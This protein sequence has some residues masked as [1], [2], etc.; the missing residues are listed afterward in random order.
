LS[1]TALSIPVNGGA[2]LA[3]A[4]ATPVAAEPVATDFIAMVQQMLLGQTPAAPEGAMAAVYETLDSATGKDDLEEG[5]TNEC[6]GLAALLALLP[7]TGADAT[8]LNEAGDLIGAIGA[9]TPRGASAIGLAAKGAAER[10]LSELA[11]GESA[12]VVEADRASFA[13]TASEAGSAQRTAAEA[14]LSRP[15]QAPVGS[16]EWSDEL[17]AR[18][19]MMAEQG[20][21]A[22][23]LRLSPEH[24]GPLEVRITVTD[25]RASVW[26]GAAHADTRA[27]LEEALP[28]LRE[29]FEAQGMSLNDAG[30]FREPPREQSQQH[31]PAG[32]VADDPISTEESVTVARARLGLV[33]AYA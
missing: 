22:A 4:P 12:D 27:A 31:V 13:P 7:R 14:A 10:L 8:A 19:T 16:S 1:A 2:S 28:R 3:A 17:A 24:L 32:F 29:L 25:D 11:E 33:D 26:F 21:Q 15:M 20:K 5:K 30:V 23:S 6:A 9:V 18:L